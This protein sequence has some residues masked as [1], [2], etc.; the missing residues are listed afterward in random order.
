MY[1]RIKNQDQNEQKEK[2]INK[3]NRKKK[4]SETTT[5]EKIIDRID[6]NGPTIS[7]VTTNFRF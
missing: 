1:S 7:I 4:I 5:I 2:P 3:R 6:Q